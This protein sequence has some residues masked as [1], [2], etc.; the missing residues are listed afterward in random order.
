M[1][2]PGVVST[3]EGPV[4]SPAHRGVVQ[5]QPPMVVEGDLTDARAGLDPEPA[6]VHAVRV[7][8]VLHLC[9]RERPLVELVRLHHFER[10]LLVEVPLE[11]ESGKVA[12][13][14]ATGAARPVGIATQRRQPV[15]VV[16]SERVRA[17]RG[18]VGHAP[19]V[20]DLAVERQRRRRRLEERH[21]Q[22]R[23]QVSR[24]SR[25]AFD[26]DAFIPFAADASVD[27]RGTNCAA[28]DASVR[29][30]RAV[31]RVLEAR[32]RDR[33]PVAEPEA[34]AEKNV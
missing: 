11:I 20:R 17:R 29:V 14:D 33:R 12:G 13:R 2:P 5:E 6:P 16:E 25:S 21:R 9:G 1:K 28:G 19:D 4:E 27:V 7:R 18:Y 22:S 10:R 3:V 34:L 32:G 8:N 15:D 31:E 23:D 30:S 26:H 24:R